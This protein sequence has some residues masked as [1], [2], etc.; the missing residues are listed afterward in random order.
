MTWTCVLWS[1]YIATWQVVTGSGLAIV[2]FWWLVGMVVF[3]LLW[4]A[5]DRNPFRHAR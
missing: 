5:P 4:L 3:G 1:G 2:A